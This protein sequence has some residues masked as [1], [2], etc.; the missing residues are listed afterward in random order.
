MEVTCIMMSLHTKY[1][2]YMYYDVFAYQIWKLH[3]L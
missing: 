2:S 1:G 3:V